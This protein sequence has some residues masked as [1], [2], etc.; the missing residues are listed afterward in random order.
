MADEIE[1]RAAQHAERLCF[2][3]SSPTGTSPV[4]LSRDTLAYELAAFHRA[5]LLELEKSRHLRHKD[6]CVWLAALGPCNCGYPL[7]GE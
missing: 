2:D 3:C 7:S 1:A 4:A 6:E 5:M